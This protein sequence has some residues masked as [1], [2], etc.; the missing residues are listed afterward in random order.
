MAPARIR[1]TASV[2]ADGYLLDAGL[3]DVA[4]DAYFPVALPACAALEHRTIE[5]VRDRLITSGRATAAELDRYLA[6]VDAGVLDLATP[7]MISA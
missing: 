2:T 6:S 1:H 5:H 7:P 3:C 4:A